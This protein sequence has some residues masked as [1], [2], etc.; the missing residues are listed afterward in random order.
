MGRHG[1]EEG[2]H[3][4]HKGHTAPAPRTWPDAERHSRRG[5]R[6][7]GHGIERA[8]TGGGGGTVPLAASGRSRRRGAPGAALPAADR[9]RHRPRPARLG[10]D[11]RGVQGAARP[12]PRPASTAS[13]FSGKTLALRTATGEADLIRY[14]ERS[15]RYP[16]DPGSFLQTYLGNKGTRG[17]MTYR[18]RADRRNDL[19]AEDVARLFPFPAEAG[20]TMESSDA[21]VESGG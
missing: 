12:A 17:K 6:G 19:T 11:R 9:T 1:H 10:G 5:G 8:S 14:Q 15:A 3:D 13:D 18:V 20:P 2:R 4:R 16:L 7:R 21:K